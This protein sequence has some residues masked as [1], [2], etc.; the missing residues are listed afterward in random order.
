MG[1]L[2][3]AYIKHLDWLL[4]ND[5]DQQQVSYYTREITMI[6]DVMTHAKQATK[7]M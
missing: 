1:D 6:K 4:H 2:L 5:G 7:T 3:N